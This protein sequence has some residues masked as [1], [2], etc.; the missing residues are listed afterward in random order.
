MKDVTNGENGCSL[1]KIS[2]EL[3]VHELRTPLAAVIGYSQLALEIAEEKQEVDI[4]E[5]LTTSLRATRHLSRLVSDML[6]LSKIESGN[7]ELS[8]QTIKLRDL[9][10][11]ISAVLEPQMM[12]NNNRLIFVGEDN[13]TPFASDALRLT[14]ILINLV[15]NANNHTEN[16]TITV[17]YEPV[18]CSGMGED[19]F[20]VSDTGC[21]MPSTKLATIFEPFAQD[22]NARVRSTPG[23][24]L[25]LTI[26]RA[27]CELLGGDI[28]VR[29]TDGEGSTFTVALPATRVAPSHD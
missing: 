9:F 19:L 25:G 27:L 20:T 24:G 26:S 14:Q 7:I 5:E 3:L 21:G 17:S 4:A 8:M 2:V 23:T 18:E 15:S 28:S 22:V 10:Y 16:G 13:D 1:G 29:S 11:D 12:A 6:D